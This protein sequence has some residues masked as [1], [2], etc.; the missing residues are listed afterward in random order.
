MY[1]RRIRS[2]AKGFVHRLKRLLLARRIGS[3]AILAASARGLIADFDGNKELE[4]HYKQVEIG[5]LRKLLKTPP[6]V[7]G[8]DWSTLVSEVSLLSTLLEEAGRRSD[9]LK[10][11]EECKA[12]ALK[13]RVKFD[14][15]EARRII[16]RAVRARDS[17]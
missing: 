8:Y 4:I 7:D 16:W 12:I 6:R 3:E 9:A 13:H 5:L 17:F 11:V 10:L 14:D 2:R 1:E 15:G